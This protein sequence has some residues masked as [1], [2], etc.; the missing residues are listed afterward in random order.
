MT[1]QINGYPTCPGF[2]LFTCPVIPRE[3][4]NT[5]TDTT[6][7]EATL[8]HLGQRGGRTRKQKETGPG[9]SKQT[10]P[11]S[12]AFDYNSDSHKYRYQLASGTSCHTHQANGFGRGA[13]QSLRKSLLTDLIERA[14][15]GSAK[16]VESHSTYSSTTKSSQPQH[17]FLWYSLAKFN[18][19]PGYRQGFPVDNTL[20]TSQDGSR[21]P[22]H[23]PTTQKDERKYERSQCLFDGV[24]CVA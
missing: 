24:C 23:H 3:I 5:C 7:V 20:F 1:Y 2:S 11:G 15:G 18:Q 17:C 14:N 4:M 12:H 6:L 21:N 8:C 22:F 13:H 9:K 19:T 16:R 10:N